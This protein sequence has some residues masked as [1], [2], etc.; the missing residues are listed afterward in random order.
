MRPN[1]LYHIHSKYGIKL[2]YV[3]NWVALIPRSTYLVHVASADLRSNIIIYF[4]NVDLTGCDKPATFWVSPFLFLF[5]YCFPNHFLKCPRTKLI[6]VLFVLQTLYTW[7]PVQ[8]DRWTTPEIQSSFCDVFAI[9]LADLD[10]LL[11]YSTHITLGRI[12]SPQSETHIP[13]LNTL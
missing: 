13:M 3:T 2:A 6:C 12:K 5:L 7:T 9:F 4:P 11:C 1:Y 8:A 10:W